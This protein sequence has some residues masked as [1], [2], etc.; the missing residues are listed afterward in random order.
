MRQGLQATDLPWFFGTTLGSSVSPRARNPPPLAYHSSFALNFCV[1][2]ELS[3]QSHSA[4]YNPKWSPSPP[5]SAPTPKLSLARP[6]GRARGGRGRGLGGAWARGRGLSAS[7]FPA[8]R[9]A[10]AS[11]QP[12]APPAASAAAARPTSAAP[13]HRPRIRP[14]LR[15]AGGLQPAWAA[16]NDGH[17][18]PLAPPR[19]TGHWT[20]AS[21]PRAPLAPG[22]APGTALRSAPPAL[23]IASPPPRPRPGHLGPPAAPRRGAGGGA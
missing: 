9:S 12:C 13:G 3:I 15:A 20:P 18:F 10:A 22:P 1:F 4:P 14:P 2:S 11:S 16:T 17:P 21:E 6:R 5:R 19:A 23:S 8:V 7:T